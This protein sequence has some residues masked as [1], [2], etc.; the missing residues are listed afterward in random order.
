MFALITGTTNGIGKSIASELLSK[1]LKVIGIDKKVN[2]SFKNKN[3]YPNKIN[4]LNKKKIYDFLLNLK[5]NKTLPECFILNAGINIY[6]N[7]GTFNLDNFKKCFDINFF[8]VIN[9]V[10]AIEKLN[11]KDKKIICISSTSNIIPNPKALGYFSSKMMLKKN[12]NLWNYNKTNIY[13]TII[14]SPV[15][16]KISRNMKKPIGIAGIIYKV[17]QITPRQAANKIISFIDSSKK[18]LHVTFFALIVYYIIKFAIFFVP[19]L[20]MKN[21]KTD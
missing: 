21:N 3:F 14:L 5:K 11:I 19:G 16:T 13:K 2:R 20:Y 7:K 15:Q 17:L 12:F 1:N 10:D 9:F 18:T 4:I 8:G 6:D